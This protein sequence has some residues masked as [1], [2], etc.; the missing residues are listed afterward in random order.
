MAGWTPF[1]KVL[2]IRAYPSST[3]HHIKLSTSSVHAGCK[4]SDENG[5]YKL[6]DEKGRIVSMLLAAQAADRKVSVAITCEPGSSTAKI[7]ELQIGEVN[8][9]SVIH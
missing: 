5:I 2:A 4:T 1:S 6:V 7:T 9:S 3:V 8:F